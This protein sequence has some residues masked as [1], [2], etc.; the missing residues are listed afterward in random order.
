VTHRRVAGTAYAPPSPRDAGS[1]GNWP[2]RDYSG[3]KPRS[4][5]EAYQWWQQNCRD[6]A[7]RRRARGWE[8]Q[9]LAEEAGISV[10]T[11]QRIERGE[12]VAAHNLFQVCSVLDLGVAQTVDIH[13]PGQDFG[14]GSDPATERRFARPAAT[15]RV[16]TREEVL[17]RRQVIVALAR[18]HNLL[19]P[20]V[21]AAGT[22]YV[23]S[24]GSGFA[25]LWRFASV[26]AQTLGVRVNVSPDEAAAIRDEADPL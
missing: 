24:N 5:R 8:Q 25:P 1:G 23:R 16:A 6:V 26:V 19:E 10:N 4:L 20:K 13:D 7:P 18:H 11:L 12:W 14:T 21:G 15:D 3:I 9:Q 2:N 22:V 17:A